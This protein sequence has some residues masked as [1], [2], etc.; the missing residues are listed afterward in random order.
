MGRTW[1]ARAI[2]PMAAL[3][4]FVGCDALEEDSIIVH[5]TITVIVTQGGVPLASVVTGE[6]C[7]YSPPDNQCV[8]R[9]KVDFFRATDTRGY[10][11]INY[12]ERIG[13]ND[14]LNFDIRVTHEGAL[15]LSTFETITYSDALQVARGGEAIIV[16]E[17]RWGS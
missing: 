6:A 2:V 12:N 5:A 13:P 15:I 4:L 9:T 10:A 14:Y 17:V 7:R 16:R 8:P 11:F 1:A 3:T